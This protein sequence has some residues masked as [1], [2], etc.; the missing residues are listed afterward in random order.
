MANVYDQILR[1]SFGQIGL[2]RMSDSENL[3]WLKQYQPGSQPPAFTAGGRGLPATLPASAPAMPAP[4]TSYAYAPQPQPNPAVAAATG[5]GAPP[6]TSLSGKMQ[7]TGGPGWQLGDGLIEL[8][9]SMGGGFKDLGTMLSGQQ[10]GGLAALLGGGNGVR[11]GL[12]N[13]FPGQR[14]TVS[15]SATIDGRAGRDNMAGANFQGRSLGGDGIVRALNHST[16]R[17]ENVS[18]NRRL[19]PS[20]SRKTDSLGDRDMRQTRKPGPGR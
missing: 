6:V 3:N 1:G 18:Q 20:Q 5:M 9:G 16:N 13:P 4:S 11:S 7:P 2:P 14:V 15:P 10:G 19:S 17:F 8:L 12:P